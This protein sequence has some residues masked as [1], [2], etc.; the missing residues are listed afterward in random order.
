M[1]Q[2]RESA[3]QLKMLKLIEDISKIN[4]GSVGEPILTQ[5]RNRAADF[6]VER[7]RSVKDKLRKNTRA[8]RA[9][10]SEMLKL[11][12]DKAKPVALDI[13][14]AEPMLNIKELDIKLRARGCEPFKTRRWGF[15]QLQKILRDTA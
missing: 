11:A 7:Q 4:V 9:R 1:E 13:M 5:L 10:Q 8:A 12:Y 2:E 3:N 6:L 14:A 15:S